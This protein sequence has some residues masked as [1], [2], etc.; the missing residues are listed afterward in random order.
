M[1]QKQYTIPLPQLNSPLARVEISIG[2]RRYEGQ[3]YIIPPWNNYFQQFAQNPPAAT[4]IT[5]DVSPFLITPNALGTLF[6]IGGTISEI[7]LIR[8]TTSIDLTGEKIIP[9]RLT[10]SVQITYAV[11][12]AVTFLAN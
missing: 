6:I 8:G 12:P 5:L 4:E 11:A 3:A 7:L 10:D 1:A 9:I 2:G